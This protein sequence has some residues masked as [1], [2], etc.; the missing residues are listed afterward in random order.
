MCVNLSV[1]TWCWKEAR[2][3]MLRMKTSSFIDLDIL[4]S[5]HQDTYVRKFQSVLSYLLCA[6]GELRS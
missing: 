1:K 6:E 5:I 3:V 4:I 2:D